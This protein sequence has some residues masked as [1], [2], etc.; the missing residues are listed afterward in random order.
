MR[1]GELL[2][3]RWSDVDFSSSVLTVRATV[4]YIAHYGYVETKPKTKKSFR[5]I[6]LPEFA[7]DKLALHRES[8]AEMQSYMFFVIARNTF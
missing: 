1:R 3:L 8:N 6:V 4:D 2:A 7:I 5:K